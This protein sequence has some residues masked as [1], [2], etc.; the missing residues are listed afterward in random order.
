MT[1]TFTPVKKLMEVMGTL[2]CKEEH[3]WTIR[4]ISDGDG[5]ISEKAFVGRYIA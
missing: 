2:Y 1:S 4:K 5:N 3:R